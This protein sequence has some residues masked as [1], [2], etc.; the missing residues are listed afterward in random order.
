MTGEDRPDLLEWPFQYYKYHH[1][2]P[3]HVHIVPTGDPPSDILSLV[4]AGGIDEKVNPGLGAQVIR[5]RIEIGEVCLEADKKIREVWLEADKKI[6][7]ISL[8]SLRN[9]GGQFEQPAR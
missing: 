1:R 9:I 8:T 2:Y 3:F 6:G 5:T 4:L 7:E